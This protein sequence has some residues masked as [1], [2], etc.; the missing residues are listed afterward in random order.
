MSLT[1]SFRVFLVVCISPG[2]SGEQQMCFAV[3]RR[4]V[5]TVNLIHRCWRRQPVPPLATG[6]A[7]ETFFF[8]LHRLWQVPAE[9]KQ[10]INFLNVTKRLELIPVQPGLGCLIPDAQR[11]PGVRYVFC[12]RWSLDTLMKWHWQFSLYVNY[13]SASLKLHFFSRT[14]AA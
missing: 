11:R 2:I 3:T 13:A 5:C 14:V 7:P 12:E 10:Q 8:P 4:L 1:T 6:T 9:Q